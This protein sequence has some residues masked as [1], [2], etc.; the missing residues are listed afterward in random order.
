MV[1]TFDFCRFALQLRPD[2]YDYQSIVD[3]K[4]F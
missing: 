2:M 4:W 3:N 1:E